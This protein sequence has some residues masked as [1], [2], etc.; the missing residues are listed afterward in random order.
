MG[1]P[2]DLPLPAASA[3]DLASATTEE[4]RRELAAALEVTAHQLLRLASIVAE[5]ERRGEDLAGLKLGL[6]GYLRRIAAGQLLPELVV[7][8]QGSPAVLRAAS[9]LPPADQRRLA[10]GEPFELVVPRPDGH[11]WDTRLVEPSWLRPSQ[12]RQLI[13]PAGIR[14]AGEQIAL[15]ESRA[16]PAPAR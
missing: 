10:S 1:A 12:L 16:A 7:L 9:M 4:L 3:A 6:L 8:Y 11:G 5:L 2:D 14:P 15:L 13:G